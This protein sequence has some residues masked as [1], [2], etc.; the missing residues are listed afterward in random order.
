MTTG[1]AYD[2]CQTYSWKCSLHARPS[3]AKGFYAAIVVFTLIAM[4]I[5]FFGINP[6]R[7]LVGAGIVQGFST[8]PLMLMIMLMTNNRAIMGSKVNGTLTN[9]FGWFTTATIF[10]ASFALVLTWFL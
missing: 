3:E 6:M 10:A 4:S 9:V 1:A 7:M 2:L 8:P 5:N